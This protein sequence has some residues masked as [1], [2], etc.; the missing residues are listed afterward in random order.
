M[1]FNAEAQRRKGGDFEAGFKA[2][3]QRRKGGFLLIM[4][5]Q[6]WV[7]NIEVWRIGKSESDVL[8]GNPRAGTGAG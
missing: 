4:G 3:G 7:I 8:E 5:Y 1:G 6:G 2:K